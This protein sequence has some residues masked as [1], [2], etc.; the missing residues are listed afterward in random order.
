MTMKNDKDA[1]EQKTGSDS[2]VI[3]YVYIAICLKTKWSYR[4]KKSA[5]GY[6]ITPVASVT[7]SGLWL[8]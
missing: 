4:T 1:K 5:Y 6:E 3:P 2:T 7:E 8:K